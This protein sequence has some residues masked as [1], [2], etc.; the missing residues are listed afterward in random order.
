M[1]LGVGDAE[2]DEP[3]ALRLLA[4]HRLAGEEV[5]LG[6]RHP[7]EERP[8]DR[9]VVAGGDT[10]PRM[11]VDD[12]HGT[13]GDRHVGEETD[14]ETGADGNAV[15]RGDDGPPAVDDVVDQ[16]SSLTE[17]SGPCVE[18]PDDLLD[19][20][21]VTTR[22]EGA[23]GAANDHRSRLRVGVHGAPH[24]GEVAM[25]RG[26]GGV[27]TAFRLHRDDEDP[28]LGAVELEAREGRG[29]VRHASLV[30]GR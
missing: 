6:L 4:A 29:E 15:H 18:V 13:G 21:E 2:R 22:G 9:R 27:E 23:A 12:A 28:V 16:I 1:D 5:V 7:A 3:D 8:D 17:H 25:H 30:T 14:D 11:A 24:V 19:Q 20:A 26:V 10:D